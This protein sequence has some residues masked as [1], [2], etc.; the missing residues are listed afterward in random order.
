MSVYVNIQIHI[1]FY[2]TYSVYYILPP[3]T[4]VEVSFKVCKMRSAHDRTRSRN[5]QVEHVQLAV[6][7]A[8]T[9]ITPLSRS[10]IRLRRQQHGGTLILSRAGG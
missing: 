7:V 4:G 10:L 9:E 5:S 6:A 2:Y 3:H 8:S 1:Y